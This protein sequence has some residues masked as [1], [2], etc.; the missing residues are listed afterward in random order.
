MLSAVE[1][2]CNDN[3]RRLLNDDIEYFCNQNVMLICGLQLIL[4]ERFKAC[5]VLP[6]QVNVSVSLSL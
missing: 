1:E 3:Y 5:P 4:L 2:A 6:I